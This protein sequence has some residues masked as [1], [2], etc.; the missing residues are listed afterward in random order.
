MIERQFPIIVK[1][2]DELVSENLN[3]RIDYI[4]QHLESL[5][6]Q[7]LPETLETKDEKEKQGVDRFKHVVNSFTTRASKLISEKLSATA[8]EEKQLKKLVHMW[9]IEQVTTVTEHPPLKQQ[10]EHVYEFAQV[11]ITKFRQELFNTE[12]GHMDR[13]RNI[14]VLSQTDI[15]MPLYQTLFAKHQ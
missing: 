15:L 12:V 1:P 4:T 14:L 9:I 3:P 2:T 8:E 10:M 13:I 11:E 5:M 6:N 7:Y